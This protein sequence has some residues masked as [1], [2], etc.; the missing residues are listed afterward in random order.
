MLRSLRAKKKADSNN[1]SNEYS[2]EKEDVGKIPK[3]LF[4][5]GCSTFDSM[6]LFVEDFQ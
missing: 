5:D 6:H 2:R 4:A 3:N 1:D